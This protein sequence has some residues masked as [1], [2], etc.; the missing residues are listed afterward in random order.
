[1]TPH[2]S[3]VLCPCGDNKCTVPFGYCHCGCGR[4]I[5]LFAR[6][7]SAPHRLN[8]RLSSPI[9]REVDGEVC[10]VI[11][12]RYRGGFEYA[13]VSVEDYELVSQWAWGAVLS[14]KSNRLYAHRIQLRDGKRTVMLMHRLVL[15]LETGDRRTG[16]HENGNSLDNRR[17]N[18]R[19][20]TY[21]QNNANK[22]SRNPSGYKGVTL[23][24]GSGKWKAQIKLRSGAKSLGRFD[25]PEEAAAAYRVA[26]IK[27]F[28]EFAN[29]TTT[30]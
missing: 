3:N 1:M 17:S 26:A 14:T 15:G 10:C 20:A 9:Y 8:V 5:S 11:P 12:L 2:T 13:L 16:D 27:H 24:K 23:D 29:F 25:T 18:L 21:S 6:G 30:G 28:G 7:H 19:V 4:K 22:P